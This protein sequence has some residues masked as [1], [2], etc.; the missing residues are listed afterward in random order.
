MDLNNTHIKKYRKDGFLVYKNLISPKS[1]E[2]VNK[3]VYG[4]NNKKKSKV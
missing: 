4:F 3:I 2:E 1:C